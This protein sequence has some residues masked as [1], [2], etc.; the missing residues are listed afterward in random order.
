MLMLLQANK[1][2]SIII[3]ALPQTKHNEICRSNNGTVVNNT[4]NNIM[5]ALQQI[6]HHICIRVDDIKHQEEYIVNSPL[7]LDEMTEF[8][9][10]RLNFY[11]K[12]HKVILYDTISDTPGCDKVISLTTFHY[13][14]GSMN[15]PSTSITVTL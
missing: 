10:S 7:T 1:G 9:R 6:Y 14:L 12:K 15:H 13:K 11:S 8:V 5:A 3:F 2:V 4:N